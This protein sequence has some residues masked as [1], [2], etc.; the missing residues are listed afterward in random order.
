MWNYL[1]N[2]SYIPTIAAGSDLEYEWGVSSSSVLRVKSHASTI[3]I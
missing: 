2:P 3:G 1:K